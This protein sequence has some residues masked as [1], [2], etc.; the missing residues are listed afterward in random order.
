MD[1]I[2]PTSELHCCPTCGAALRDQ[3]AWD[4]EARTFIGGRNSVRFSK[5]EAVIFEALWRARNRGGI[6]SLE[7][8]AARAY[9]GDRD[10]G[11]ESLTI[12]SV[13]LAHMRLKLNGSGY[14]ITRNVGRPRVGYRVT[15]AEA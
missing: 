1:A 3:F 4:G 13:H 10:G 8:F 6:H 7:E 12:I 9:E 5:R 15:K 2:T 11:P 14:T